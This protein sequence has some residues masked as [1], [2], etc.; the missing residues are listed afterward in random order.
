MATRISL[1]CAISF[2]LTSC[3]PMDEQLAKKTKFEVRQI[4][5]TDGVHGKVIVYE[6]TD[7]GGHVAFFTN[8]GAIAQH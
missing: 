6:I 3:V 1:F 4:A 2:L 7:R 5:E 8:Y